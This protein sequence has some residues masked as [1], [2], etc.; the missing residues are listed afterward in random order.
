MEGHIIL[1][2]PVHFVILTC[3]FLGM[4]HRIIHRTSLFLNFQPTLMF[5]VWV[6][7]DQL[8]H[9][10]TILHRPLWWNYFKTVDIQ[11]V[12]IHQLFYQT[13]KI[14]IFFPYPDSRCSPSPSFYLHCCAHHITY[15]CISW[16]H[17]FWE[18]YDWK[19]CQPLK[20]G[21]ASQN[22]LITFSLVIIFCSSLCLH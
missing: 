12:Q 21:W 6:T 7:D 14:K 5:C 9:K 11:F 13:N 8:Y 19:S 17:L 1:K 20:V 22:Y 2:G 16:K 15:C 3:Y 10:F 18:N 4:F